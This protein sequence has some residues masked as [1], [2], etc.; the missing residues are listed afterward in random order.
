MALS[1][2]TVYEYR[3]MFTHI[4][5]GTVPAP[6]SVVPLEGTGIIHT[7]RHTDR[8]VL[9]TPYQEMAGFPQR[10]NFRGFDTDL[11]QLGSD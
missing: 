11:I 1:Y 3:C 5:P 10:I 4:I 8:Q 2:D 6:L 7:D 9:P